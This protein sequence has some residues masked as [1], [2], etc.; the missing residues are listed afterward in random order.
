MKIEE[1]LNQENIEDIVKQLKQKTVV[2]PS[3]KELKAEYEPLSHNIVVDKLTY[4]DKKIKGEKGEVV[5]EEKIT[6]VSIG[7][8]KLA[9]RRISQFLFSVPV[10]HVLENNET[11]AEKAEQLKSIKKI[12]KVAKWDTFNKDRCKAVSSQCEQ[13]TYWYAVEDDRE[14]TRY[15]FKTRLKLKCALFSPANGDELYPLFDETK[16]MIAFSRQFSVQDIDK[17]TIT[18]FETWTAEKYY[19]WLQKDS[20]WEICEGFP[21]D[22]EL[23]KIPIVY[24]YRSQPIWRDG[25]NGKVEQIE[26]LLSRN[27]DII[28]Y[29]ASPVLIIKG[30]LAGN[31]T[32]G[33]ANKVFFTEDPAGGAEY[34]SWQQSPE[35]V[36]FQFETLMRLFWMEL[37]LPDLSYENIKGLGNIS[38]IA[39]EFMFTDAHLKCGEESSIYEECIEREYNIIKAFLGKMNPKWQSSI[40]ELE[41]Y[42]EIT[43][44]LI[45]DEKA[46]VDVLISANG[47]KPLV[48]HRKSI[49][50]SGMV[51]DAETEFTVIQAEYSEEQKVK[52]ADVFEGNEPTE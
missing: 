17:K 20:S 34:A 40:D 29:H 7:L 52:Y 41:V 37:Q 27:G 15:G 2:I 16:D 22:N 30:R 44:F 24:S 5:K 31:P 32:K 23:G 11:N 10:N 1:I 25:D 4:P 49:E 14:R 47:G 50:L 19:K 51:E 43:P 12:F 33:E 13:A 46:K 39:L 48:S 9:A 6:R 36:R 18:Y 35:S 26:K 42:S 21:K 28:D 45:N 38:G 3:W 8:Q